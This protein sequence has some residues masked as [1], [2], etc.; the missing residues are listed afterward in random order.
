MV[1]AAHEWNLLQFIVIVV[2]F[3]AE[4]VDLAMMN[5][6][7]AGANDLLDYFAAHRK[8]NRGA[9]REDVV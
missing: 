6:R 3:D 4:I 7:I 9:R 1:D 2:L 8:K 5:R